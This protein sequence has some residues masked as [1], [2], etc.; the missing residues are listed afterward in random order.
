MAGA[1]VP[2]H[3]NYSEVSDVRAAIHYCLSTVILVLYGS[4]VCP[5]LDSL[6]TLQLAM[7][8]AV[9]LLL[10]WTLRT[11]VRHLLERNFSKER[12]RHTFAIEFG[13]FICGGVLLAIFN[14]VY[15]G[16]PLASGL[17]VIV[18]FFSLGFFVSLDLALEQERRQ[19]TRSR[20]NDQVEISSATLFPVS[21]KLGLF[22]SLTSLLVVLILF[23]VVNKDLLWLLE[24]SNQT[25]MEEARFSILKEFLFV[26]IVTLAQVLN[27]IRSY[28]A[29]LRLFFDAEN[30]V[31]QRTN[32]GD[33][34]GRVPVSTNDEFGLMAYHTNLMVE[35]IHKRTGEIYRTQDVTILSL[36]S[37]AETR[38][39]ETGAH[40]LRTQRYVRALAEQL[41][42][43]Q[44][45]CDD[46]SETTIDLLYK[47]APLHDIG[48]VGIPD[49]ILLK[50]GK[51]T[52]SEFGIMKTHA[53]L[54]AEAIRVAEGELGETS[55]LS[56]AR[57][58]TETHHEKW[59]GSGYPNG[60]KGV[61]IPLS[62]R[63]MAVADVY[64]ALISKRVYKPAFSH[65][66]AKSII[67]EGRGAHFDPDVVDAF[68][69]VEREFQ[70]I[71]AEFSDQSYTSKPSESDQGA[72]ETL[73]PAT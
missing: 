15:H 31:L 57:E 27:I 17:K 20:Q 41:K 14:A 23:L 53:S 48:K 63:L 46:L 55:F 30:S 50:P 38:D 54:G 37:L 36:A 70:R 18:G 6:T 1:P 40:I 60:L 25:N 28:S 39:N 51:L 22:A 47:S 29:N 43:D 9:M 24:T 62:G 69:A 71:A 3:F 32:R 61:A 44:R 8:V 45:Y 7:P 19:A 64:D 73:A 13:L 68:I 59:D 42:S 26:A 49:A 10:Q 58:I 33:L 12:I 35:A 72:S 52:D 16:F 5:F 56:L 65:D 67:I 34:D 21:H 11:P 2:S 4:R 66:K